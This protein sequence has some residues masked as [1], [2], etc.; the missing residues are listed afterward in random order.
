MTPFPSE[1]HWQAI[2]KSIPDAVYVGTAD[3]IKIANEPALSMLGF[4]SLEELNRSVSELASRLQTRYVDTG[5]VISAED[6]GYSHALRGQALTRDVV[7]RHLDTGEDRILRSAA[8]PVMVDGKVVAAVAVNTDITESK[9]H[10][11]ALEKAVRDRDEM[12]ALVS[13]DLR[14]Q[15]TVVTAALALL[16]MRNVA[17]DTR[18]ML[19]LA[20]SAAKSMMDLI[21]DLMEVSTLEAGGMSVNLKPESAAHL[22]RTACD[23]FETLAAK[24]SIKLSCDTITGL[25]PVQADARRIHQV[26]ANLISNAIKFSPEGTAIEIGAVHEGSFVRFLVSDQGIGIAAEALPNVFDRFW[27]ARVTDRGSAG[28]GLAIARGIVEA[29]GGTIWVESEVGKGSTFFFT[30]PEVGAP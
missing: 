8:A 30:L 6:Q 25:P 14:N 12:L 11:R 13:H 7:I 3:G 21:E 19:D 2:L 27:Q 15:L 16:G 4:H 22:A 24:K 23:R 26:F 18:D 5:A 9:R 17:P 29:H 28:L 20:T 10:E 1:A